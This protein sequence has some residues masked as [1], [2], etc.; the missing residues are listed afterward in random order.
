MRHWQISTGCFTLN[1]DDTGVIASRGLV[2][3]QLGHYEEAL[4]D[5]NRAIALEPDDQE[6]LSNRGET[7]GQMGRYFEALADLSQAIQL[8]QVK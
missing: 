5:F 7:Y 8:R 2:Y 3:R 4:A 6:T 1:P